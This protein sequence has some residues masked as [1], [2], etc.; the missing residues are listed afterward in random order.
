MHND[1]YTDWRFLSFLIRYLN[2]HEFLHE[3]NNK[4]SYSKT[5]FLLYKRKIVTS[6]KTC[7]L[8]KN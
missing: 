2:A 6:D 5:L 8:H 4:I 1:L 3:V 7:Y